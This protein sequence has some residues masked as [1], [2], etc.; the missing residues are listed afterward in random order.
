MT[1]GA[2]WL[3]VIGGGSPRA[4]GRTSVGGCC[5][6]ARAGEPVHTA[7]ATVAA[8]GGGVGG[9]TGCITGGAVVAAAGG[10]GGGVS[11][12]ALCTL[13]CVGSRTGAFFLHAQY[14]RHLRVVKPYSG[15]GTLGVDRRD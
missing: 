2:D 10:V 11:S 9:T 3:E 6:A 15:R 8:E 14:T 1:L 13:S 4:A 12:W 5:G 7:A